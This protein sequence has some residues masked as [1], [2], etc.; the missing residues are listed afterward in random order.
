[1]SEERENGREHR[2]VQNLDNREERE[3]RGLE[4][5]KKV[6]GMDWRITKK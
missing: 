2:D 3:K 4:N 6:C 1:M 5:N